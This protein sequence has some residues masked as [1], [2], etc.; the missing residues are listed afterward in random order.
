MTYLIHSP[1]KPI[2]Q[3]GSL[4]GPSDAARAG[5]V[6]ITP[7]GDRYT[8]VASGWVKVYDHETGNLDPDVPLPDDQAIVTD[9]QEVEVGPVTGEIGVED[10]AV[11]GV[12][13]PGTVGIVTDGQQIAVDGG[14]VT[15]S[16]SGGVVSAEFEPD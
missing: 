11:T 6:A 13:L 14:T 3:L 10:G 4:T 15:I 5:D 2:R 9:G 1:D 16:V 8:L 7:E 12:T